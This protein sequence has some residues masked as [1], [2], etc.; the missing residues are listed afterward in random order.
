M[1]VAIHVSKVYWVDRNLRAIYRA[2][3]NP[4]NSSKPESIRADMDTL[5]DIVIFDS[6]NQPSGK[7]ILISYHMQKLHFEFAQIL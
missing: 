3:K 4:S 1:G 2:D 6:K 7:F 5:R